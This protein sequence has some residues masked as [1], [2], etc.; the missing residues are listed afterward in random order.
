M[1][2]ISYAIIRVPFIGSSGLPTPWWIKRGKARNVSVSHLTMVPLKHPLKLPTICGGFIILDFYPYPWGKHAIWR[3]YFSDRLV[4][5]A[6]QKPRQK[7]SK[8]L[9]RHPLLMRF[10][11]SSHPIS[12]TVFFVFFCCLCQHLAWK[13]P[14]VQR[15]YMVHHLF[16]FV[17]YDTR[18]KQYLIAYNVRAIYKRLKILEQPGRKVL[19]RP[20]K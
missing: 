20:N 18:K 15:F 2:I 17:G 12:P 1:G 16:L 7:W 6:A 14:R 19:I 9:M 3:A 10:P 4:Q 8:S 5:P 11:M 13:A